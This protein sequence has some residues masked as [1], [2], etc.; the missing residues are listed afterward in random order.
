MPELQKFQQTGDDQNS[1]GNF[2]GL[3]FGEKQKGDQAPENDIKGAS[4]RVIHPGSGWSAVEFAGKANGG[5]D[6]DGEYGLFA[7]LHVRWLSWLSC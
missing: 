4:Q 5:D 2:P 7:L 3:A 6:E 1:R